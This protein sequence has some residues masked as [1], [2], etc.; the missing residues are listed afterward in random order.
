LGL[1]GVFH[2]NRYGGYDMGMTDSPRQ[3]FLAWLEDQSFFDPGVIS[4][5]AALMRQGEEKV[6]TLFQQVA[7]NVPAYNDFL[8]KFKI[9][10]ADIRTLADFR[11]LPL[12]DNKNY[13]DAYDLASR[14][15][16]GKLSLSHFIAVSSG[17]TGQPHLWPRTL[18]TDLQGARQHEFFLQEFFEVNQRQ[19][20]VIDGFYLGNTV[21]GTFT[22]A[23][24]QLLKLKGLPLTITTPSWSDKDILTFIRALHREFDQII[25]FGYPPLLKEVVHQVCQHR[26]AIDVTK[27]RLVCAG[28]A[29][30][31]N[32]RDYLLKQL[33]GMA[34]KPPIMS[35]YGSSDAGL[36]GFETLWSI[37]IRRF[38]ANHHDIAQNFFGD[39]RLPSLYV[40]DPRT[41]Y[42]ESLGGELCFTINNGVPLIRYNIKD[43]GGVIPHQQ[44]ISLMSQHCPDS[45]DWVSNNNA[46]FPF[47]YIFGRD[48]F[49]A[50]V[51]GLPIYSEYIQQALNHASL[52]P[53]VTGN[54]VLENMEDDD[55]NILLLCRVELEQGI[56]AEAELQKV[57][58]EIF[59]QGFISLAPLYKNILEVM[60]EKAKPR[61]I[62]YDYQDPQYFGQDGSKKFA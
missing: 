57:M 37:Q 27:L 34:N 33:G 2:L 56:K 53:Y 51:Y 23:C 18:Q 60:G 14:S 48:R 9:N 8:K 36:M 22:L 58:S 11:Q 3:Q 15:W 12:T 42:F 4:D 21:A 47:V 45:Q 6:L 43:R 26:E 59:I 7:A 44:M 13:L 17:T 5:E 62:L 24:L 50:K 49:M 29:F 52:A 19:T 61:I 25:I 55:H 31:E 41:I 1:E 54:F 38:L 40:Y 30:T 10:P 39:A 46:N 32:W 35:V 28:Q 16:H 20:L